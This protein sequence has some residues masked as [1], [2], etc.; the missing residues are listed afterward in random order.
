MVQTV[1]EAL[2][3]A[4]LYSD[5]LAYVMLSL[6]VGAITAAAGVLAEI[7]EPFAA[8]IADKDEVSLVVTTAEADEF[9]RRLPGARRSETTYRLLTFDIALEPTLIGFMAKVSATLAAANVSIM[10]FAAFSRDHIL[11]P[12]DQFEQARAALSALQR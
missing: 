8:L 9:S 2:R 3:A 7:S 1:D 11:V 6:P 12:E 10:P 4:T 5:E